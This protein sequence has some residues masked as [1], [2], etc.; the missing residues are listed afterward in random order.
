MR[1]FGLIESITIVGT[2]LTVMVTLTFADQKPTLF[3]ALKVI[4]CLPRLN[5]VEV[6]F[7]LFDISPS[8]LDIHSNVSISISSEVVDE[9][10]A[11][12][13]IISPK[14]IKQL[15]NVGQ[16][17]IDNIETS[18]KS[19]TPISL[20]TGELHL[21]SSSCAMKVIM[22]SPIVKLEIVNVSDEERLP[23]IEEDQ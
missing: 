4:V 20:V 18:G 2:A 19:P 21:P 7:K 10:V 12:I 3:L 14:L 13:T 8:K 17:E 6:K 15:S 5:S 23:S 22:C 16:F 1:G 11:E 9:A